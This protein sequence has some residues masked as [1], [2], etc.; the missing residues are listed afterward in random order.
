[1]VVSSMICVNLRDMGIMRVRPVPG[2]LLT[3]GGEEQRQEYQKRHYR[4][5][6]H[7]SP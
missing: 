2:W 5:L 1:M 6:E 7:E 3:C 4:L